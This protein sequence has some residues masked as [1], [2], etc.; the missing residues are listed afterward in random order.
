MYYSRACLTS[1]KSI[2]KFQGCWP[3]YEPVQARELRN[4]VFKWLTDLKKNGQLQVGGNVIIRR[5]LFD[6][7][8]G[9]RYEELLLALSTMVLR[10]QVENGVFQDKKRQTIGPSAHVQ[11]HTSDS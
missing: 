7:C 8:S 3:I 5:S 9:E 11:A 6:D 1:C 10:N 2:Q 4:I